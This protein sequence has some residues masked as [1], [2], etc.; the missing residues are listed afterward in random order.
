MKREQIKRVIISSILTLLISMTFIIS[1]FSMHGQTVNYEGNQPGII[2]GT[3]D[4]RMIINIQE[5]STSVIMEVMAMGELMADGFSFSLV[6]DPAALTL[7]DTSLS[8]VIPLGLDPPDFGSPV[9]FMDP[10]FKSR[11]STFNTQVMNH[12]VI[13]GGAG[14][15][16]RCLN[17]SVGTQ[18]INVSSAISLQAQEWIPVF[19]I[20]FVKNIPGT[21]LRSSDIGFFNNQKIPRAYSAWT[22]RGVSINH[23]KGGKNDFFY[24]NPDLFVYRSGSDVTTENPSDITDLTARLNGSFKRGDM[25]SSDTLISAGHTT[26]EFT[27]RLSSDSIHHYGFIYTQADVQITT[28][29]FSDKLTI[30]GMDYDFP[31]AAEIS[32]G[33]FTRAGETFY[34]TYFNNLVPDRTLNFDTLLTG[35]TPQTDYY[36]WAFTRYSFETSQIMTDVGQRIA[37]E[38]SENTCIPPQPPVAMESQTFC[39][40]ATIADLIAFVEPGYDL[41]W[42]NSANVK[43]DSSE[44]LVDG[45]TYYA[46]TAEGDC[47]SSNTA[48]TVELIDG[49]TPP[50]AST[51]QYFCTG[52]TV[53]ELDAQG[54]DIKWYT[55]ETGGNSLDPSALLIDGGYYYAAQSS[56]DCESSIRTMV[57]VIMDDIYLDPPVIASP[58]KFCSVATLNDIATDGSPIVWYSEDGAQIS[59]ETFLNNN[60]TYYAAKRLGDCESSTRT[61][62]LVFTGMDGLI[63][64]PAVVSPQNFCVGSTLGD[65]SVPN[66]QIVWYATDTGNTRLPSHT[67]LAN[68]MTYYAAQKAG[69][70]E[71]TTRTPVKVL[72]GNPSAPVAPTPQ[73]FCGTGYTIGDLSVTG[74]GII[75]YDAITNG[76]ILPVGTPLTTSETTYY[77][78]QNA[79]NCVSPR[80]AVNAYYSIPPVLPSVT[81]LVVCDDAGTFDLTEA[82]TEEANIA[83]IYYTDAGVTEIDDPEN[84]P[85]PLSN[86][87][88][89]VKAVDTVSGCTSGLSTINVQL[90]TPPI[91]SAIPAGAY[92]N[93]GSSVIIN[94]ID[95]N[96]SIAAGAKTAVILDP[97]VASIVLLNDQITVTGLKRG[98][99][100]IVYTSVNDFGCETQYIIPVQVEGPPTGILM[101]KDI[102]KCNVPGGGDIE[103]VQ[104]GYIMGGTAPWTVTI[105]DNRNTFTIDTVVRDLDQLP[106]NVPVIIP[107]NTGN[108]PEYTTYTITNIV[109]ASGAN[110]Q[111]HYGSV[112]IGTNPSP[113]IQTIAN[114]HQTVCSGSNTLPVSFNGVAT[115]YRWSVD[116]NIGLE[117]YSSNVIPSFT[118][119]NP[120]NA[121][122]TAQIMITPE[123]WFNGVVCIGE[124]DTATITVYPDIYADFTTNVAGLGTIRF[125]D[126]SSPLAVTWEWNFGDHSPID[127]NQNPADHT[128]LLS[129]TYMVTLVVTSE[130]GC[131]SSI[132]KNITVSTTTDLE[133]RYTV[134]ESFQCLDGNSFIFTDMSRIS[135][136]NHTITAWNW[137]FGDG[138]TD[139]IQ[140]PI[141]TYTQPGTYQVTLRVTESPGG[142]Q[143]SLTQ[144][145]KVL[146]KPSIGEITVLPVCE[147]DYL[148]V[149]IPFIHWNGNSPVNGTWLLDGY[150]FDPLTRPITMADNGKLLQYSL[151][152]SCGVSTNTGTVITVN[153]TPVADFTYAFTGLG[154]VKFTDASA[155]AVTWA[156]NFGDGSP[157]VNDQNPADHT[158]ALPGTYRVTLTVTSAGGCTASISKDILVYTTT[159]LEAHFNVNQ[160]EQCLSGNNFIFTDISRLTTPGFTI[161]SWRWDFGDGN[162]D[163]LQNPTHT[164]ALPGTYQVSLVVTESPGGTRSRTVQT[165]KVLGIPVITDSTVN[166]VC[167]GSY[168]Q[169]VIPA[170]DWNGNTPVDGRWLLDGFLF[171]PTTRTITMADNGKL[172]QYRIIT[173]CGTVTSTGQ[174]ITVNATPWIAPIA[175]V[176]YCEG[177]EVPERVLGN[178]G[179]GTVYHWTKTGGDIGLPVSSGNDTIPSFI[180]ATVNGNTVTAT[181]EVTPVNGSCRGNTE[182]FTITVNRGLELISPTDMGEICSGSNFNY[183][184]RSNENNV[185]FTWSRDA[186]AGINGGTDGSGTGAVINEVLTNS[187]HVPVLVEYVIEQSTAECRSSDIVSVTVN[188]NPQISINQVAEACSGSAE[189]VIPYTLAAGYDTLQYGITFD[190]DAI[191]A[192]FVNINRQI[193][194]ANEITVNLPVNLAVGIYRGTITVNSLNGCVG[195]VS[196][197]FMIQIIENVRITEQPLPA[198]ICNNDGFTLSVTATGRDL[199]Y[200][201]YKDG[202]TIPNATSSTYSV[203]ESDEN[204]DFGRY[205]VVVTGKC[206]TATSDTVDVQR[207]GLSLLSKWDDVVFIS[208]YD[209]LFVAYQWYKDGRPVAVNGNYQSYVENG[210]LDGTYTVQVTYADGTKE[211]S[212]PFVAD[213]PSKSRMVSIYPNP[214]SKGG[215]FVVDISR[216]IDKDYDKVKLEVFDMTGKRVIYMNMESAIQKVRIHNSWGTYIIRLTT[217]ENEVVMEKIV[218]SH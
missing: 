11:Y 178:T 81:D 49:L 48:V 6:Y 216:F 139:T 28:K 137:N 165:V 175:N 158:Y 99:T 17:A 91:V 111:T 90:S 58:Q 103:W 67:L 51:P 56:G 195:T 21:D 132:S 15:G 143:S 110:K 44:L 9:I 153:P 16:M 131:R 68:N 101:G 199:A 80:T 185:S 180:A 78:E 116:E 8:R 87:T 38:T 168:L 213:G 133:A 183:T 194:P 35:L 39:E 2:V 62:V 5:N 27:G 54:N 120:T 24:L 163:T 161:S 115:T 86:T 123:Y 145:V 124:S 79:G 29:R 52:A 127:T 36:A 164:Y 23:G 214:V 206:G 140:N 100:E 167:E 146:D 204:L 45:T 176:V 112:R 31:T 125:T 217:A 149:R 191:L 152:S 22:F 94:I 74:S 166:P 69:D 182:R 147:G 3:S 202:N 60:T 181:I 173:P 192:G 196:Y 174:T 83:Y 37:F 144:T 198:D 200:Q 119:V 130:N 42:Y 172:L 59:S 26:A 93:I 55:T 184:A 208:N 57:K 177:A 121:P 76:N 71:S 179:T 72:F 187:T 212:C 211:M 104:I 85:L 188:P 96:P 118:A 33:T 13:A 117:N 136:P 215:E 193:L 73:T 61:P 66:N 14:S 34:I 160:S 186:I 64:P 102:V 113:V 20:Y 201:W 157:V 159:D 148:Q 170:I 156:W 65:I 207:S 95:N 92:T 189:A 63:D 46:R 141:H 114:R 150:I 105:S 98:N 97:A 106:L 190:E 40:G 129:G 134:N 53:A 205:Y 203:A 30:E 88:Y 70:C 197:P 218:V 107:E 18:N 10:S 25:E 19:F 122:I 162:T 155:N 84:M 43:L 50:F 75:W 108:V 77:A 138:I 209:R 7:T 171:D 32:A 47:E 89:Y 4:S 169:V 151:N 135:T 82:V 1:P 142:S 126:A 154:R 128:Y 109:D 12:Q 210:G 41:V